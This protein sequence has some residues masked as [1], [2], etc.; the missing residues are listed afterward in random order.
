M[1]GRLVTKLPR[2]YQAE[3]D[4]HITDPMIRENENT[5]W[6]KFT[7]WLER[8][9]EIALSFRI[10][11]VANQQ[12]ARAPTTSGSGCAGAGSA[13]GKEK[14]PFWGENGCWKCGG[15]GHI[16]RN[17]TSPGTKQIKANALGTTFSKPTSKEGWTA[18][19]PDIQTKV[20]VCP[21]CKSHHTYKRKFDWGT[22]DW[23]SSLLISCSRFQSMTA[24]QRGNK[25]EELGGCSRCTSWL[26]KKG[27]KS[28]P[29]TKPTSCPELEG[30]S[31]CGKDHDRVLHGSG[32]AY[33]SAA[34][35]SVVCNDAVGTGVA[36][37]SH[38]GSTVLLEIQLVNISVNETTIKTVMFF[39]NGSTA[40]MC[41]HAWAKKTG[42]QGEEITYFMRVVGEEYV[43][44]N[45]NLYA[46]TVTDNNG[47]KHMLEAFGIDII[48]EVECLPDLSNLKHLFPGVP[49]KVFHTPTG[50]ADILIG[51]N[52]RS[53]Q[54]HSSKEVGHL[55]MVLTKFGAGQILTGTDPRIGEGGHSQTYLAK[56]M[57]S[58][59]SAPPPGVKVLYMAIKLPSFFEA[60]ELGVAPQPHC[61]AC[62]KKLKG[63][64]DCSYR[65]QALTKD[66]QDVARRVEA[67]M[68][69][70]KE[71][72]KIHVEYPFKPTA[73]LQK[74]NTGQARAMLSNIEKRLVRDDLMEDYHAEMKKTLQAGSVIKLSEEE[75]GS[76]TGPVHYLSHFPIL[77]TGSVTPKER[78]VGNRKMKN[79]HTGLSQ[80]DVVDPALMPLIVF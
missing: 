51:S 28:C 34:G 43:K 54:P 80:N 15:T 1:V 64:G 16:G 53:L 59:V 69:L 10:R 11:A 60:E 47:E 46:L 39:D 61:E 6:N 75:L 13:G 33:C 27:K 4:R 45:T 32:S 76:W 30:S 14:L 17:C 72:K 48:T 74:D 26:H 25:L 73:Y 58:A 23:P 50:P 42:L 49:N 67:T 63:C 5:D 52:Y 20:G 12:A 40:T 8:Q 55:R 66:Q 41:T 68:R 3:W 24:V 77:K 56:V 35:L 2:V 79:S 70:D 21:V 29:R 36:Q 7:A 65:G 19:S 9:K 62:A 31:R 78:I 22:I 37:C 44:R 18:I 57:K 71:E 38:S